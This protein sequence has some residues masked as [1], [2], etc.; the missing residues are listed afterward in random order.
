MSFPLHCRVDTA[1]VTLNGVHLQEMIDFEIQQG[2]DES[3]LVL[4][5]EPEA[6]DTLIVIRV[7]LEGR[8][9]KSRFRNQFVYER[10]PQLVEDN[11]S[12]EQWREAQRA[13]VQDGD[14][15][16]E[17][18]DYINLKNGRIHARNNGERAEG[19]LLAIH[20]LAGGRGK[21]STQFRS[22]PPGA[23]GVP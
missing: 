20:D 1:A 7:P 14:Q 23:H 21:D 11:I 10:L 22:S 19:P 18:T 17:T 2:D 16:P 4:R 3:V 6:G 8:H 15:V 5:R 9:G 12:P 13:V